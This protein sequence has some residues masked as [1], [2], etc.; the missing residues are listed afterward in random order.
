MKILKLFLVLM[1][2]VWADFKNIPHSNQ[3]FYTEASKVFTLPLYRL[4]KTKN[5]LKWKEKIFQ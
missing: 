3:L 1:V 5:L 4:I 2:V